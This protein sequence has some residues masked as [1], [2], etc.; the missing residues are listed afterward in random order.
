M[1]GEKP[2]RGKGG[3]DIFV[4]MAAMRFAQRLWSFSNLACPAYRMLPFR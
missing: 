4:V 1:A 2:G 3:V